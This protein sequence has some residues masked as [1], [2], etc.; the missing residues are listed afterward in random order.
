[1]SMACFSTFVDMIHHLD[2]EFDMV[3]GCI[4]NGT[5]PDLD[6]IAEVRHYLEVNILADPERAA[7]LRRLGRPSSWCGHVWLNL[8]SVAGDASGSFASSIPLNSSLVPAR[9]YV[10]AVMEAR[11]ADRVAL[12]PLELNQF[13]P[14]NKTIKFWISARVIR[15][16][17]SHSLWVLPGRP[18]GVSSWD[19]VEISGFDPTD[20]VPVIQFVERRNVAIR[21]PDFVV[22][23]KELRAA[24]LS[25]APDMIVKV[26]DWTT[27]IDVTLPRSDSLSSLLATNVYIRSLA[28][29]AHFPLGIGPQSPVSNSRRSVC[30]TS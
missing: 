29:E 14:N 24:M 13:K 6:G 18:M 23:K 1:M 28:H 19:M 5:I 16:V 9:T 2:M 11:R 7:E 20:G 10:L 27:T 26:V 3:V 12:R 17:P 8:R 30:S 4:A 25:V 21:F 22:T 15:S